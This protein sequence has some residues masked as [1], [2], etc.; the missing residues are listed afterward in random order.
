MKHTVRF[1]SLFLAV[2]LLALSLVGCAPQ[3]QPLNYLKSAIERSFQRS[4]GGEVASLLLEALESGSVSVALR[5]DRP[6]GGVDAASATLY[7]DGDG[8]RLAA[9]AAL[10][11]GDKS[12]DAQLWVSPEDVVASS[13]AFLGSTT[14]GVDLG[15]LEGD[16]S[17]SIFRNDSGTAYATPE[18]GEGSAKAVLTLVQGFFSLY[19]SL[20]DMGELADEH[21]EVFLKKLTEHA[22]HTRYAKD[23]RHFIYLAVDNSMLS[24]ALRDTWAV[25]VKDKALCRRLREVAATRDAMLSAKE[26]VVYTEW[27]TEVENWLQ[28][29][30]EI[31]AL[32]ARIDGEPAFLLEMNATVRKL[33]GTVELF[34]V[35]YQQ[36]GERGAFSLDLSEKDALSLSLER[37]GVGHKFTYKTAKDGWRWYEAD[38]TYTQTGADGAALTCVGDVSLDKKQDAFTLTLSQNEKTR[39][40]SGAFCLERNTFSLSVDRVSEGDTVY[41]YS[42]KVSLLKKAQMPEVPPFVNLATV[43]EARIDPVAKRFAEAREALRGSLDKAA[44]TKE[45]VAGALLAP[46]RF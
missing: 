21:L 6:L 18:I 23:G 14:L 38:L 41:P 36:N 16:L 7:F 24:R 31:E 5:G 30:A 39:V 9:D 26:G 44:F 46:F 45:T 25:A 34:G 3:K 20:E 4:L 19:A 27:T 22:R 8:Q 17:H 37:G 2:C 33:T 35:S 40:L 1:V 10:T 13:S 43:T 32:C 12:Y 11:V 15:T 42:L 29:D 28:N